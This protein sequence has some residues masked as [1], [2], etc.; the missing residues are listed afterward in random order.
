MDAVGSNIRVDSRGPQVLRVLPRVHE[1][2]NEEW[3]SDKTRYAIDGDTIV[4]GAPFEA[5][6]PAHSLCGASVYRRDALQA[7]GGYRTELGHWV[8]TF[9]A[10]AIGLRYGLSLPTYRALATISTGEVVTVPD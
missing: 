6:D 1:A 3:I 2:V 9:V 7:L 8:D 5:E 10:R 4:V